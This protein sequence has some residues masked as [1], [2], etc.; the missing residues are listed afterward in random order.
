M[1]MY[2]INGDVKWQVYFWFIELLYG[3]MVIYNN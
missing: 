3:Y 1:I 2:E